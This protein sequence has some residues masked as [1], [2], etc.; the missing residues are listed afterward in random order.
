MARA[1]KIPA[2]QQ[3]PR[4][5]SPPVAR[6]AR[7]RS[8]RPPVAAARCACRSVRSPLGARTV[9]ARPTHCSQHGNRPSLGAPAARSH[10]QPSIRTPD[11]AAALWMPVPPTSRRSLRK[12]PRPATP[13]SRSPHTPP[14]SRATHFPYVFSWGVACE[15]ATNR[16]ETP[17]AEA[18][19]PPLRTPHRVIATLATP[20]FRLEAEDRLDVASV[21]AVGP[22]K[23]RQRIAKKLPPSKSPRPC[24]PD[25]HH[26]RPAYAADRKLTR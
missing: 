6:C 1:V 2:R 3:R 14:A 10:R 22:V 9:A 4:R 13:P 8:V 7:R 21:Q 15:A 25:R 26:L 16:Q 19:A 12:V 24:S 23:P 5:Q 20:V 17:A 18:F 11:Y